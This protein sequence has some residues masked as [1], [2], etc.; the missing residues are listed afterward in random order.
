MMYKK[1]IAVIL[2]TQ[3]LISCAQNKEQKEAALPAATADTMVVKAEPSFKDVVYD[4]KKD[5][6]CGMPVTAGVSDT[7]HYEGK[8]YGFCAKE[9]KDEFVKD[10]KQYL[11]VK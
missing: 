4:S 10:P 9:C 8:V 6:V 3:V 1:V 11:T 2:L 7:A 5:L